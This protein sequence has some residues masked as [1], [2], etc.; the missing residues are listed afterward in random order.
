MFL[1]TG[2]KTYLVDPV[3]LNFYERTIED[4]V[5]RWDLELDKVMSRRRFMNRK[6]FNPEDI[7]H[8]CRGIPSYQEEN[9]GEIQLG[10]D[11]LAF[12]YAGY[13]AYAQIMSLKG[14]PGVA[15]RFLR[16]A[17]EIKD[18]IN[19]RFWDG[20][21]NGFNTLYTTDGIYIGSGGLPAF[22]LYKDVAEPGEKTE[23]TLRSL[24]ENPPVNIEMKSYYPEILY[25][26]G[27]QD[28]AY[29]T[30]LELCDPQTRRR[31]YP[32]VSYA[33]VGSLV[34]G[35]MGIEA[36]VRDG[37]VKTLSRLTDKIT[38]AEMDHI[39][40]FKSTIRVRHVGQKETVLTNRSG[41]EMEW[42]ACFYADGAELLVNGQAQPADR[43][44]DRIGNSILFVKTTVKAGET[45]S[46]KVK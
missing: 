19:Q 14:N 46:V 27:A 44:V 39:P 29:K 5:E 40:V 32:E 16:K 10:V 13:R 43:H 34:S 17:D 15:E 8:I 38:W 2:D 30:I 41:N 6:T 9:P 26:Y 20:K 23:R 21:N 36:D 18:F 45:R 28:K 12:Q 3:F 31:E 42:I 24:V 35:L 25:R 22:L 1:W 11:L 33:A 4:Y 37:S 7:F